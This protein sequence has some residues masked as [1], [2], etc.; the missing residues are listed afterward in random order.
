MK[1]EPELSEIEIC[2]KDCAAVEKSEKADGVPEQHASPQV[3]SPVHTPGRCLGLTA[4][5]SV[6]GT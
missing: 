5:A 1:H 3:K 4:I 2:H 6:G